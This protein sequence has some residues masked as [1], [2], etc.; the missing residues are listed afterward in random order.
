MTYV[1]KTITALSA[2]LMLGLPSVAAAEC[3]ADYKAKQE[4][5]ELQLHYGVIQVADNL[6]GDMAAIKE[7]IQGRISPDGWKVLRVMSSFGQSDLNSKQADAG[8]YFL[9]Y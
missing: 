4:V 8:E 3:Y 2:S 1:Q 6:C 9:R 5:E 7:D